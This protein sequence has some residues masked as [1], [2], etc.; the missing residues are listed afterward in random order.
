MSVPT[1]KANNKTLVLLRVFQGLDNVKIL[2]HF[3]PKPDRVDS[4]KTSPKS[5]TLNASLS[6]VKEKEKKKQNKSATF[7]G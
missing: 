7:L 5:I 1:T 3:V 6:T 2:C 4:D